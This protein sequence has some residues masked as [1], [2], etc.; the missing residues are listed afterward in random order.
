MPPESPTSIAQIVQ[1]FGI[2]GLGSLF[3]WM[4]LTGRL[5]TGQMYVEMKKEKEAS[6]AAQKADYEKRLADL[7]ADYEKQ[8]GEIR[9]GHADRC[10]DYEKRLEKEERAGLEWR[11][12]ALQLGWTAVKATSVSE[13]A[14]TLIDKKKALVE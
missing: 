4:L 6:A 9:E 7:R 10:A 13:T 8:I 11:N 5:A 14:V 12:T 1:T 3:F 2:I